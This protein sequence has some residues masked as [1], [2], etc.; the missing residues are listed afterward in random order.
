MSSSSHNQRP[1]NS[2]MR[3]RQIRQNRASARHYLNHL[4]RTKQQQEK[5]ETASWDFSS[6]APDM[7]RSGLLN[8]QAGNE[9]VVPR[10]APFDTHDN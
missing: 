1:D 9:R 4:L 10:L 5:K 6:T 7:F 3:R 2:R 8:V